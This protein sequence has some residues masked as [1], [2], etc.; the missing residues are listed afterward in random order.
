MVKVIQNTLCGVLILMIG[1]MAHGAEG[2]E[3][4]DELYTGKEYSNAFKNP[5][6][7]DLP[8]V[9]LIGDSISIAYTVDVRKLLKGKA[10]VFRIPTN[11]KFA[12]HG[13]RNIDQWLGNRKWDIIHFNWGLW[14]ICYR[15]PKAKTQ[16]HRDKVNGKLTA[17]PEAYRASME[18]IVARLKKTNAKLIWCTTTPVPEFEAGRKVGDEVKYN[19]IAREIMQKNGIAIN[20]LHAHALLKLPAIK[21]GK[22]NVHFTAEGS[23]YL[24][25]KVAREIRSALNTQG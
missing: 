16:G 20:D 24:A 10:D 6:D 17:T 4:K 18:K 7:T 11:G 23:A 13:A 25:E 2:L 3:S 14:D 5:R 15:N 12:A 22:G 1:S 8:N 19:A 21:N 9:L